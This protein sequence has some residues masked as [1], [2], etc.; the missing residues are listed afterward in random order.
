[1][2]LVL[3]IVVLVIV[4]VLLVP[5]ILVMLLAILVLM[6]LLVL[7]LVILVL[8]L[9]ILVRVWH[10]PKMLGTISKVSGQETKVGHNAP[11]DTRLNQRVS[12]V[13]AVRPPK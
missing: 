12:F 3:V 7:V 2:I 4:L 13:P 8:L 9:S 10:A 5:V 11:R 1:V 6:V